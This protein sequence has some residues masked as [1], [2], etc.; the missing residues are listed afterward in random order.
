MPMLAPSPGFFPSER[1]EPTVP[2]E[3]KALAAVTVKDTADKRPVSRASSK[4][5]PGSA[6]NGEVQPLNEYE[7]TGGCFFHELGIIEVPSAYILSK[8]GI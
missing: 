3:P 6:A 8:C 1:S 2:L 7:T 4:S 5:G